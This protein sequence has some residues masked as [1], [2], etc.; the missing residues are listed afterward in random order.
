MWRWCL[1]LSGLLIFKRIKLVASTKKF[2]IIVT[3]EIYFKF[4]NSDQPLYVEYLQALLNHWVFDANGNAVTILWCQTRFAEDA[5]FPV[6]CFFLTVSKPRTVQHSIVSEHFRWSK[7]ETETVSEVELIVK[8]GKRRQHLLYG[9][10]LVI[11]IA[12]S[13]WTVDETRVF[14]WS[15]W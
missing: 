1:K 10:T 12:W 4:P 6:V 14:D 11:C 2:E 15:F 3:Q 9:V 13:H 5:I 7:Y 8:P